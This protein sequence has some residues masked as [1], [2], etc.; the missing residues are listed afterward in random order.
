MQP[1]LKKLLSNYRSKAQCLQH[2][3]K[4]YGEQNNKGENYYTEWKL[5]KKLVST[6]ELS[7]EEID[8]QIISFWTA[9]KDKVE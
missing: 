8:K 1:E 9:V 5:E 6:K 4:L 2:L 3:I 7:N